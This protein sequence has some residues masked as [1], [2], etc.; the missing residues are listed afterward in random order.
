MKTEFN[1]MNLRE[2]IMVYPFS[3]SSFKSLPF[4]FSFSGGYKGG[5]APPLIAVYRINGLLFFYLL[6]LG[7]LPP[8]FFLDI[9]PTQ[10]IVKPSRP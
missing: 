8:H 10:F 6:D 5:F 2:T 3:F 1:I 4:I 7:P 9:F